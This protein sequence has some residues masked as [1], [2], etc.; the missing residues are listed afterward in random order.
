MQWPSKKRI[1]PKRKQGKSMCAHTWESPLAAPWCCI[2]T[3]SLVLQTLPHAAPVIE[4]S[5]SRKSRE[6]AILTLQTRDVVELDLFGEDAPVPA[7]SA[8]SPA[9]TGAASSTGSELGG[10]LLVYTDL[11]RSDAHAARQRTNHS[12]LASSTLVQPHCSFRSFSCGHLSFL[13]LHRQTRR[14]GLVR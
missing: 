6:P 11:A 12:L 2:D 3:K 10:I 13:A 5:S 7:A 1:A 8:V 9:S 14:R 4:A